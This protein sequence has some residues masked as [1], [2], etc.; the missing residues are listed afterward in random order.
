MSYSFSIQPGRNSSGKAHPF[1][2]FL[3]N[4]KNCPRSSQ[5]VKTKILV[6]RISTDEAATRIERRTADW[7][8]NNF[9]A[10][11]VLELA[12]SA[13]AQCRMRCSLSEMREIIM[14]NSV[15]KLSVCA[16]RAGRCR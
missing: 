6:Q 11:M 4:Y 16:A 7:I 15:A 12:A 8:F 1:A 14:A 10:F 9:A 13:L 5:T 3:G 2:Q